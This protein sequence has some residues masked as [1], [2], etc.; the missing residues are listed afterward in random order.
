MDDLPKTS[1]TL[2]CKVRDPGDD[3]A[4]RRFASLYRPV[5]LRMARKRGLQDSDS[6]DVA[7]GVMVTVSR[8]IHRFETGPDKPP[9]RVWLGK[10][11]HNA[12]LNALT[13]SPRDRASGDSA[14]ADLLADYPTTSPDSAFEIQTEARAE[15]FRWAASEIRGEFSDL[16]WRLFWETAVEGDP[17]ETV[18]ERHGRS[19]GAVYMARFR[20]IR[21]LREKVR[22]V[23]EDAFEGE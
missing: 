13:R 3:E 10:I 4:W 15:S 22:E 23:W 9:F 5:V 7:Q 20:V 18:A 21:R 2:I 6:E 19:P 16:V 12:I 14:V 1:E 17:V 11:A 8:A